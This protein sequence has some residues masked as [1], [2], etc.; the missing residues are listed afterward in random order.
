MPNFKK[1][2]GYKMKGFTYPG[3]SPLKV[4]DS[5]L[6]KMQK[7]LNSAELD[8][9][10][11]GWAKVARK[12]YDTTRKVATAG[13]IKGEGDP[14]EKAKNEKSKSN[15]EGGG[16]GKSAPGTVQK[17][18]ESNFQITDPNERQIGPQGDAA[19]PYKFGTV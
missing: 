7:E 3:E 10:E 4:S 17:T 14:T 12:V 8:F 18:A 15:G 1:S 11:P 9:K 6:V 13:M 16:S 5:D 2:T 19:D